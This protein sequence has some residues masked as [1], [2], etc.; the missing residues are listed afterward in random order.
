MGG[1]GEREGRKTQI[2][3]R[4]GDMKVKEDIAEGKGDGVERGRDRKSETNYI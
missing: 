4:K 3:M 1:D 2:G